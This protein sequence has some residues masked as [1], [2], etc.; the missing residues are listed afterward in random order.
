ML[1]GVAVPLIYAVSWMIASAA[2]R[3]P[4]SLMLTGREYAPVRR[5]A[6]SSNGK[7]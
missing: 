7:R 6:S 1:L 4:F 3:T 2:R 5:R